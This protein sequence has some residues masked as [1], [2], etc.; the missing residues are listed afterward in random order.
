MMNHHQEAACMAGV[1]S[2]QGR[3]QEVHGGSPAPLALGRDLGD[4]AQQR[5]EFDPEGLGHA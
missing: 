2:G 1:A 3:D 5:R 4:P